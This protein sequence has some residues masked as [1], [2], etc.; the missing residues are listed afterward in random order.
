MLVICLISVIFLFCLVVA[1]RKVQFIVLEFGGP[2]VF[3]TAK[4]FFECF[5]SV[6][7]ELFLGVLYSYNG[8]VS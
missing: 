4:I 1:A 6:V 3:G 5:V 8:C 2:S 7:R